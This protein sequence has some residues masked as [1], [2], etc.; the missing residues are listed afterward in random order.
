VTF[1]PVDDVTIS[2]F[3]AAHDVFGDGSLLLVPTPGHTPGSLSMLL[4]QEGMAPILFVGDLTYDLEKLT[5]ERVPGVGTRRGLLESTR[6]VNELHQ[7]YPD[8]V[9]LAAHDPGAAPL[10]AHALAASF[11]S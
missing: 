7:T 1:A 9:I 5:A 10:L 8:L 11:A 2:P 6:A 3:A 4:R